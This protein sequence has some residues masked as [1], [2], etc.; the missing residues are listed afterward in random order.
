MTELVAE[1]SGWNNFE[2]KQ[3]FTEACNYVSEQGSVAVVDAMFAKAEAQADIALAV[4]AADHGA[5]FDEPCTSALGELVQRQFDDIRMALGVAA[6]G[7][8][9]SQADALAL[10]ASLGAQPPGAMREVV[11]SQG[12]RDLYAHIVRWLEVVVASRPR[13]A[14][15][16]NTLARDAGDTITENL[17]TSSASPANPFKLRSRL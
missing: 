15:L 11:A 16:G 5:I 4:Y 13:E 6:T 14:S 3:A 8:T 1:F 9:V 2:L 10:A 12:L 17:P 7:E